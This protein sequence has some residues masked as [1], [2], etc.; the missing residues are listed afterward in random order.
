ML[1]L[2]APLTEQPQEAVEVDWGNP[3]AAGLVGFINAAT[4]PG[5]GGNSGVMVTA[6]PYA[7]V[8]PDRLGRSH[9]ADSSFSRLSVRAARQLGAAGTVAY[10]GTLR[11]TGTSDFAFAA[12][13]GNTNAGNIVF[14]FQQGDNLTK[15]RGFLRTVQNGSQTTAEITG[16]NFNGADI[17]TVHAWALRYTSPTALRIF[18]DGVDV[19]AS[20]D[21]TG[22]SGTPVGLDR[23]CIGAE[24]ANTASSPRGGPG[25]PLQRCYLVAAWDR[26]L[27]DEEIAEW[28]RNPWQLFRTR[29]V[30]LPPSAAPATD[31]AGAASLALTATGSLA[32]AKPVSGAVAVA[33]TT[34]GSI[35]IA[36]PVA[37]AAGLALSA[38]GAIAI[39][40]PVAG[41]ATCSVSATGSIAV[42]KPV[43]GSATISA[44]AAGSVAVAKPVAGA[45]SLALT[46]TG[47]LT[48]VGMGGAATCSLAATGNVAVSKPVSGAVS[49]AITAAGAASVAKPVAGNAALALAA[50]GSVA[51]AKPVA[52]A[53]SLALVAGG[54][55]A[56]V[57]S[58]SGAAALS[59]AASG[60]V[61]VDKGVG[62]A[63]ALSLSA[64]G[65]I[66]TLT[67][68][69]LVTAVLTL[70][71]TPTTLTLRPPDA[72][73][74]ARRGAA[75]LT[76][77]PA[78][79]ATLHFQTDDPV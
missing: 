30:V 51:V 54:S 38:S 53:A 40:K 27:S 36:K 14:G 77:R 60:T 19:T 68:R 6:N 46:S 23:V 74:T 26:A 62:G 31:V 52:G 55:V 25:E 33:L 7:R 69:G 57:K 2:D 45:A 29:H 11:A 22:A 17:Q 9:V 16:S 79:D 41:A 44:T 64:A 49:I 66:V 37:G 42:A 59:L 73:L 1:L 34:A 72:T 71:S 65:R 10:I 78:S 48:T 50:S 4:L 63:A 3:L 39:A 61:S 13:V 28:S 70:R 43:S 21:I 8:L 58:V 47:T 18:R 5:T 75:S 12:A 35:A 32:V 56:I 24:R 15:P 20:N 76:L 67:A